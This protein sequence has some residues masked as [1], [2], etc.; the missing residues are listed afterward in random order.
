[1]VAIAAISET[2]TDFYSEQSQDG[3]VTVSGMFGA[4]LSWEEAQMPASLLAS[5]P[6]QL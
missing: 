3:A 6:L 4:Y 5:N 2:V 1:M